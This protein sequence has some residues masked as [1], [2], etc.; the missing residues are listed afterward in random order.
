[1]HIIASL[2]FDHY[3]HLR[4]EIACARNF[5]GKGESSMQKLRLYADDKC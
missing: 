1:M 4:L 3:T 5:Q 2:K